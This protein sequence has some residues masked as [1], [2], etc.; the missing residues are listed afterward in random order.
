L[1]PAE[2]FF[3]IPIA[4]LTI[5]IFRELV[6]LNIITKYFLLF[7]PLTWSFALFFL[8]SKRRIRD[9]FCSFWR[10][11]KMLVFNYPFYFIMFLILEPIKNGFYFIANFLNLTFLD[12]YINL[13][14][15]PIIIC[16]FTNFYIKR[17]HDQ[18]KFYFGD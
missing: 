18:S 13:L 12:F 3:L 9:L 16:I 2:P 7:S 11:L 8:D 17:V 14:F 4:F 5:L 6:Y 10:S 15:L 1:I